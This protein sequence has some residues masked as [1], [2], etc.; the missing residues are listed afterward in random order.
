MLEKYVQLMCVL[1]MNIIQMV[2]P[3]FNTGFANANYY[4]NQTM[5]LAFMNRVPSGH[6]RLEKEKSRL[7]TFP[8]PRNDV[9]VPLTEIP[10]LLDEEGVQRI[11]NWLEVTAAK[12]ITDHCPSLSKFRKHIRCEDGFYIP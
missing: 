12:I 5:V 1:L 11:T 9:K 7:F 8:S 4:L 10:F 2:V 3:R 6:L